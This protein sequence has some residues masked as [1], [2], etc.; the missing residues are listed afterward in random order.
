MPP[1]PTALPP[2]S[3][4]ALASSWNA[5]LRGTGLSVVA[6]GGRGPFTPFADRFDHN[7][8]DVASMISTSRGEAPHP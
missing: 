8:L 1:S 5:R 4:E 6:G 7:A 3:P 2:D